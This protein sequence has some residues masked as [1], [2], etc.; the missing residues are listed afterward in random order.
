METNLIQSLKEIRDFR[1]SQGRRYSLW[2]I[3]L[4]V[5]NLEVFKIYVLLLLN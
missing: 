3:L 2:L 1:G 4:F 5:L